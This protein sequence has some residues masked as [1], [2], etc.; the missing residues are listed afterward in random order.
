MP[1]GTGQCSVANGDAG[2]LSICARA[3]QRR[4]ASWNRN[5]Q[6]S[7]SLVSNDCF[8]RRYEMRLVHIEI[9]M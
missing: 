1:R 7:N 4:D 5:E 8:L 6:I 3:S 9:R 2:L